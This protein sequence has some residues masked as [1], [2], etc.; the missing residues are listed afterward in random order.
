[1]QGATSLDTDDR[2]SFGN[3]IAILDFGSQYSQLIARRVRECH[4]FCELLPAATSLS[5]LR[6]L[7]ARG[8]ILSGG[9]DSVYDA[10]ARHIEQAIIESELPVLGIC[11]GMQLMAEQLG[12]HVE[13]YPGRREYGPARIHLTEEATG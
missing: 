7:G 3:M 4:V 2:Q 9:P 12:G 5:T 8:V 1:M 11:Y 13:P 10:T 6:N